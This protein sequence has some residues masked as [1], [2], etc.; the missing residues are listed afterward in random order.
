MGPDWC[1]YAAA[2]LAAAIA[3]DMDPKTAAKFARKCADAMV[4]EEKKAAKKREDEAPL[5]LPP[6]GCGT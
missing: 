6:Y 2:A 3:Q 5:P 4:V 1:R